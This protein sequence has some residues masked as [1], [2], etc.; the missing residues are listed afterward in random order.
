M[1]LQDSPADTASVPAQTVAKP[2]PVIA[3]LVVSAF[4]VILNETTMGVALTDIMDDLGITAATGAWLTTG[5]LLTMAIVIPLTG[6]LLSRFTIRQVFFS[7]MGLFATGTLIA[8]LAPG[9][10]V[11]LAGRIVQATGTGVMMPLLFTTVLTIVPP[12]H[13][14]R[15]MGVITI[16]IAVA[17]AV[18]P[19]VS[20]LILQNLTWHAIFWIVLPIAL[21]AIGLGAVWVRNVTETNPHARFDV[22]SVILSAFGFGGLIYGLSSIGEAA[23]GHALMPIW[24]PIVVG[25]VAL[26]LF[27]LRQLQLQKVDGALLDL[28]VFTSRAFSLASVLVVIVMAALF[29]SLILIPIYLQQVLGLDVLAVGLVLLPGGVLMGAMAPVVGNLF[30]RFGPTPLVIPGTA[31]AAAALWGM[32]TFGEGTSLV[33]VIAVHL[34]LNLGLGLV[35]TPLLT[36]A[37]GSLPQRLYPHGSAVVGTI[38]QVAG[39][40]GT[41]LFVT[42][43][44]VTIASSTS[45]GASPVTATADGVHVAFFIGAIVASAAVVLALFVRKPVEPVEAGGDV[46]T[47]H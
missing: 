36:S 31:I 40:A 41:A 30:D 39:A 21:L 35:F 37:L 1:T 45:A 4:V 24:I 2:G 29:G 14:G 42:L 10:E 3:L 17:P 38:Q 26:A 7:A 15:M 44:S 20:G 18:G 5:F 28:R 25:V 33:W 6:F 32:A 13:R 34:A 46:L 11:L 23:S 12:S 16:V 27:V 8:A 9:F 19:T 47:V 22:L 43:M